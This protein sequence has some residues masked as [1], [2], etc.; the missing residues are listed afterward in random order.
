[1]YGEQPLVGRLAAMK[2]IAKKV[3]DTKKATTAQVDQII[4]IFQKYKVYAN[5][6]G[7]MKFGDT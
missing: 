3:R 1:L 4:K 5:G 6:D 2:D 7:M